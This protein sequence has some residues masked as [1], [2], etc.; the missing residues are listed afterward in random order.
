MSP[1][2]VIVHQLFNLLPFMQLIILNR[3]QH[4]CF[5]LSPIPYRILQT[6]S[7]MPVLFPIIFVDF[8]LRFSFV[9]E[10]QPTVI[11]VLF[12]RLLFSLF[13]FSVRQ[14]IFLVELFSQVLLFFSLLSFFLVIFLHLDR[15]PVHLN[16]SVQ[17]HPLQHHP[18]KTA[19]RLYYP[20]RCFMQNTPKC[21]NH[22]NHLF[23]RKVRALKNRRSYPFGQIF[24]AFFSLI[25]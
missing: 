11:C 14:L 7:T 1:A 12:L 25:H 16:F 20:N 17:V 19:N 2:P 10:V 13:L 24:Q 9:F 21:R 5:F 23:L 4:S 18:R 6:I 3:L 8:P 15:F 22:S